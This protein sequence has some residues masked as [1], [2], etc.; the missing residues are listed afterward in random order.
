MNAKIKVGL[1][2]GGKSV[3]NEIS[4]IS[5]L[6]AKAEFSTEKY[7]I[8][9]IYITKGGEWYVGED[10]GNI[11][12]Y[13]DIPLLLKESEKV[14]LC[15][16]E[17]KFKLVSAERK[18]FKKPQSFEIDIAFPVVH[19]TNVED[20]ALQGYLKTIGIPFAG[21]DVTA[22]ALGMDKAASKAVLRQEGIPVLDCT[23]IYRR[24]YYGDTEGIIDK[25]EGV[26]TYPMIVK[27]V[28]LGSSVGIS[29]AKNK[30]EL[31]NSIENA[32]SFADKVLAESAVQNLKEI[33]CSVL[34]D[35]ETQIAS[36]CEEPH[37]N[38]EILSYA[39][40][41]LG[42]E[43][44]KLSAGMADTKRKLPADI[45]PQLEEKV[46]QT[47]MKTFKALGCCGVSRVDFLYDEKTD[48]LYVNEINTIPG[49]LSF[50]LWKASGMSFSALLDEII[51]LAFKR[52]RENSNINYTFETNILKGFRLGGNK[53][54]LGK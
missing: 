27:P 34:G 5:A 39:D 29:K 3:E 52:E 41:Y 26:S 20:G 19:G 33:N 31:K 6:Q 17:G 4:V 28:N 2:F 42:G 21:C 23:V 13:A 15:N 36:V 46:K 38:D 32:F 54:K 37:G 10:I 51:K 53:T 1:I 11:E 43:K 7:E 30:E 12:K 44:A 49:S 25:I 24:D 16:E 50:Y 14:I 40:K 45:S 9:P 18:M 8:I 48:D 47:A 35:S 22:S